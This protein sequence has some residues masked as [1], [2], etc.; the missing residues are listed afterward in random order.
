MDVQVVDLAHPSLDLAALRRA[1]ALELVAT[2][3]EPDEL[4]AAIAALGEARGLKSLRLRSCVRA[5][6]P[7][8]GELRSLQHLEI[9]D[10]ELP[11]LPAALGQL[12]RLRSLR[13]E[14]FHLG[15]LPRALARLTRLRELHVDAH[16]LC[17]LPAAV[18]ELPELRAL[19]LRLR[20]MYLHDWQRPAH[21][22]P[23]FSQRL[24]DLFTL[25]AS[26]PALSSLTLGEPCSFTS[27]APVFDRLPAEFAELRALETLAIVDK[28]GPIAL[29][30]GLVLP[31]LRRLHAG[32]G[33][34]SATADE[35]R[36][37]FP[38][39]RIDADA[40]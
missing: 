10:D 20:H 8:F 38:N 22:D 24:E 1:Q 36:A 6:P 15:S 35:L 32:P 11:G 25:L 21:F 31:S 27:S 5:L 34:F 23:R 30:P 28:Y 40:Q 37:A 17:G 2:K 18:G 9:V 39:A 16:H 7:E 29:A 3:V 12:T 33:Q 19:T 26:A 13:L 4:A 14:L